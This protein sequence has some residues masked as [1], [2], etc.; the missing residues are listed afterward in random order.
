[1][2]T[3]RSSA[4]RGHLMVGLVAA[5]AILLILS[6]VAEQ[7]WQ[8]VLR[9][10]LE[11]EMI[12]RAQDLVRA[13]KLYRQDHA[14]QLPLALKDLMEPGNGG[15][16]Y[17]RRL[18]KDPLVKDGKWG[19]LFATPQGGFLDPNAPPGTDATGTSAGRTGGLSSAFST[20]LSGMQ[21]PQ[22]SPQ[23]P[24]QQQA[25]GLKSAFATGAG[26][27]GQDAT[28][29]PIAGVK[30]LCTK[31]TFRVLNDQSEYAVWYFTVFELNQGGGVGGG[32]PGI[33][34]PGGVAPGAPGVPGAQLPGAPPPTFGKGQKKSPLG[35]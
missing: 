19:L 15:R 29:L 30:S 21:Q 6:V 25:D 13:L 18:W 34:T 35:N 33:G 3:S 23:Q 16:Y 5:V 22:Q 28:G 31:K 24:Q 17:L 9:R 14:G 32:M 11:A 20:G 1:M 12:F 10:D 4:E 27:G 8:D 7:V 2:R 26:G